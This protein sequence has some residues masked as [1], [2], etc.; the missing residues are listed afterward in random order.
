MKV[1]KF[2]LSLLVT[3]GAVYLLNQPIVLKE[4]S[5]ED[6]AKFKEKL[7]PPPG[8]F[9]SRFSGFWQNAESLRDYVP[10][11][12]EVP[13]M[14]GKVKIVFDERLVPHIFAENLEDAVFAQG[15]VTAKY[16]L[17]QMDMVSRLAGGRLSEVL[18][19]DLLEN[20]KLQRRRGNQCF[21]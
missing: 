7:V 12:L 21:D 15:Y 5:A 18:G 2:L 19:K 3:T 13:E 16:R 8:P 1:I 10:E 14:K 17:W 6:P 9:L 11:K 4:P 20:D